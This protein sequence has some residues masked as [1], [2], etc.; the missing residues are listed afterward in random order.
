MSIRASFL[1]VRATLPPMFVRSLHVVSS[2]ASPLHSGV[3][4]APATSHAV[5]ALVGLVAMGSIS[6]GGSAVFDAPDPTACAPGHG[7]P[8]AGCACEDGSIVLDTTCVSGDCVDVTEL[9]AERCASRGGPVSAFATDDDVLA[10]PGCST[11]CDRI[12]IHGCELGC[13]TLASSCERPSSCD[14]VASAFWSCVVGRAVIGCE[15]G[16]VTVEGCDA[17]AYGLCEP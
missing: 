2:H 6:C 11:L 8:M 1:D 14:P 12:A 17:T 5:S 13:E 9:C 10:V 7:C 4:P 15:D 3:R 16:A